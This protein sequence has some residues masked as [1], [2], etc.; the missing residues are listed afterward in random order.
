[1]A[2]QWQIVFITLCI[3]AVLCVLL[4]IPLPDILHTALCGLLRA[5]WKLKFWRGTVIA[6]FTVA[7]FL[8][9]Q[10]YE[11]MLHYN[12]LKDAK[13]DVAGLGSRMNNMSQM[14]YH[15]RNFYIS[16]MTALLLIVILGFMR[17]LNTI[18]ELQAKAKVDAKLK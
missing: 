11:Q 13:D 3:E 16:A 2:L 18:H 10:S 14:F 9:Y 6:Y 4:S 1:M 15:Q 7:V 12:K 5:L 8:I 17:N